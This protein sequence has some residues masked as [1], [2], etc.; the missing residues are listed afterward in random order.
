MRTALGIHG[1]NIPR[2]LE[3]QSYVAS[4]LL[5]PRQL[6]LMPERCAHKCLHV[7]GGYEGRLYARHLQYIDY[8]CTYI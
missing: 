7:F 8:M 1:N 2:V 4:V 5:T 6:Y 3:L